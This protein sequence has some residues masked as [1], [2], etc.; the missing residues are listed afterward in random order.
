MRHAAS[1]DFEMTFWT[2]VHIADRTVFCR[3]IA[4]DSI[5]PGWIVT[6][7][8]GNLAANLHLKCLAWHGV[9]A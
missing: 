6:A 5:L 9:S 1:G 3:S 7:G 8:F 2:N 4:F